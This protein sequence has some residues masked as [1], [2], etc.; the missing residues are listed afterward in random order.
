MIRRLLIIF[1]PLLGLLGLFWGGCKAYKVLPDSYVLKGHD[2]YVNIPRGIG[3]YLGPEFLEESA[4]KDVHAPLAGKKLNSKQTKILREIGYDRKSYSVLFKSEPHSPINFFAVAN[5]EPQNKDGKKVQ[6]LNTSNLPQNTSES[7]NWHYSIHRKRNTVYYHAVLPISERLFGEKYVGLVFPLPAD[8]ADFSEAENFIK[9]NLS[10]LKSDKIKHVLS[11][12]V[13]GKC[14]V[15]PEKEYYHGYIIPEEII[16]HKDYMLL[17]AYSP[18]KDGKNELIYYRVLDPGLS[19]GAFRI[20]PGE[21]ILEYLTLDG[22]VRW[23]TSFSPTP[24][25]N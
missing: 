24:Q 25:E 2:Y 20:C 5:S 11:K 22:E 7:G 1:I 4:L 13:V 9:N 16:N 21:Y 10:E 12:T 19:M 8:Q 17:A 3:V 15:D 18:T 6:M 14:T 23:S